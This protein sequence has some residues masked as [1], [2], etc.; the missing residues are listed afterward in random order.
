MVTFLI[1][2]Y[3]HVII[4][5]LLTSELPFAKQWKFPKEL[6]GNEKNIQ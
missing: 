3:Q 1:A 2:I 5:V 6:A 4:K